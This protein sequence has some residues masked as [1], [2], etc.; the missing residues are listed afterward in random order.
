MVDLSDLSFSAVRVICDRSPVA[1]R[2]LMDQSPDRPVLLGA[3]RELH[4][5]ASEGVH[6]LV[7]L[8]ARVSAQL[9]AQDDGALRAELEA[10]SRRRPRWGYPQ[11]Y[12]RSNRAWLADQTQAD[13]A[14][15]ARGRPLSA[16]E[17]AQMPASR[18]A[19]HSGRLAARGRTSSTWP[20]TSERNRGHS[21]GPQP[22]RPGRQPVC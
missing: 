9:I 1:V 14:T 17:T 3:D 7:V 8:K 12:Q 2:D 13:P 5:A 4:A 6:E 10:F 19:H 11:A 21:A 16:G 22:V 15:M 20:G 18:A